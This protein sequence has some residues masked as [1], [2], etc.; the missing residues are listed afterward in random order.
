MK[1]TSVFLLVMVAGW[2]TGAV[3]A[4][5]EDFVPVSNEMLLDPSPDDW[6]MFSR[7]YDNQR[8]SPLDQIHPRNVDQL[9]MVWTRGL[10]PGVQE[11]IPIVYRGV[12]YVVNPGAVVQALD[13]TN[14]DLI[15]EYRRRLPGDL[16]DFIRNVGRSRTVAIYEDLVF[17]T[18]PDGYVV[19]LDARTGQLRWEAMAQ[20]YKTGTQHTTG[21]IVVEGKVVTGRSC[22]RARCF[23]VAHDARTGEELWKF[24]TSA[25]PGEPG[26]DTWGDLPLEK[27]MTSPWGLPGAYDPVRRLIYWGTANPKPHTRMKR[28]GGN[29]E[30]V[31]RSAP[32]ELY[33]NSTVALNPDTGELVWYYQHLPGD[34]WDSDHTQ[35]R[36]LIR[37]SFDPDPKAVKWINPRIPRGQEREIVV[38]VGEPGGLWVLDGDQGQ[39]LWAT[40]FPY[41]V[42]EFHVSHIDVETGKTYINWDLVLKKEGDRHIICFM[43]TKGY[44]PM[45][46]HPGKNSLYIPFHDAC[47]DMTAK[48]ETPNGGQRQAIFRPGSDPEAFAGIAKVNVATGQT[49][50]IYSAPVPGNGAMLATAGDL[51]FWGDMDR[52]FRAFDADTGKILW[53][54]IVGGI[55]QNS[56]ITYAVNG[57]Q[58]VAVLTGDGA[59]GT[60]GPLT[61]VP[62]LTPVR[63][64]NAIY[65]FALPE[66]Q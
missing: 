25:A 49:E 1:R 19:A 60:G 20:D 54:T 59:S 32:S 56:T 65:V 40:P 2:L 17:Y 27:R 42:P 6:L 9:R 55:I 57:R 35:E 66:G 50:R 7:T 26:G 46:Y 39:F 43:N 63:G 11:N 62:Q 33:S 10:R 15:W 23:I 14:G 41:D 3:S 24:Y 64:H 37:T 31:P 29:H 51:I 36:I 30:A 12:M 61:V 45:A 13:A 28:H 5:V 21:P 22:P 16:R 44:W 38:S 58:Y 34:D 48:I 47:L 8:F 52:R 4:Q 53:E 18:A